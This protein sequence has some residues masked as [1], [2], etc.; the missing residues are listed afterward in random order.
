MTT[1]LSLDLAAAV[2]CLGL[3]VPVPALDLR[4]SPFPARLVLPNYPADLS[5]GVIVPDG[6]ISK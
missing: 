2:V 6:N 3:R 1:L 5:Y 4:I